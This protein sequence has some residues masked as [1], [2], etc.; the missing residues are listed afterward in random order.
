[1]INLK[2]F[3]DPKI[4]WDAIHNQ[5][6]VVIAADIETKIYRST[7]LIDWEFASAFGKDLGVH[8]APWECPDFF[9]IKIEGTDELK[10]VLLQ[11]INPGGPNGGSATQYFVGD[12]DGKTFKLDPAFQNDL[13]EETAFWIDFGKDNYAGVTFNNEPKG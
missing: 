13:K 2:N 5:W 6:I 10:W 12:F 8:G 1:M 11:S 4:T 7:N 9:P 3:R